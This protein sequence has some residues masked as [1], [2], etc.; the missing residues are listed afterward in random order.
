MKKWLRRIAIVLAVA[1]LAIQLYRPARTN[2]PA[3][4]QYALRAPAHVQSILDRSCRD[5]HTNETHWPW[6]TNVAPFSWILVDHVNEGRGE[7]SLSN[8]RAY[9]PKEADHLLEEI[10]E[11]TEKGNMP[12]PEYLWLHREARLSAADKRVLCVW[13]EGERRLLR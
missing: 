5:C 9:T 10:C 8:F 7:L 12:L 11:E 3:D 1:F 2:P 4:P 13:A 6:Y